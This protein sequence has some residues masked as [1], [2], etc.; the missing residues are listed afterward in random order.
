VAEVSIH[1]V[2]PAE[3]LRPFIPAYW[4]VVVEGEGAVED[5]LRPEW[6]SIRMVLSG[7]WSFGPS[8]SELA[9]MNSRAV[10]HGVA[11]HAQWVRGQG[12]MR[13][14]EGLRSGLAFNIPIAP[15]AW[16]RLIG[17]RAF[18]F[19]GSVSQLDE[20]LGEDADRLYGSVAAA[21]TLDE[22]AKAADELL[23]ARLAK[24]RRGMVSDLIEAVSKGI[25]DPECGTVT[26][27]ARRVNMSQPQLARFTK[28]HFGFLP[29]LL[30]RRERFLRMF[31]SMWGLSVSDWSDFLDPQYVDQSHMIR[32]FRH[33]IGMSPTR[34]FA[35]ER[36]MRTAVFVA[37]TRAISEGEAE[38][39]FVAEE[40]RQT[41]AFRP[42][43][44]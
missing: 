22:R 38:G 5:L 16:Y 6:S 31:H 28:D 13:A 24:S 19:A 20:L 4:D 3:P 14:G 17:K 26:E 43:T 18:H 40:G 44:D 27:L 42:D 8:R 25:A 12:E 39:L 23:L 9:P 34:Y 30:I 33:F 11:L 32:D 41:L 7:H 35:L 2:L 15:L 36:P 21:K 29:K 37:L 10:V 1:F